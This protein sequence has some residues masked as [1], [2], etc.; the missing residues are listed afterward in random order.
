M[1]SVA[2]GGTADRIAARILFKVLRA[3]SGTPARYSSTFLG[4]RLPLATELRLPDFTFFMWAVLQ[5]L[6][7]LSKQPDGLGL[8]DRR[9]FP[10]FRQHGSG[11]D[12][13]HVNHRDGL[14]RSSGFHIPHPAAQRKISNVDFVIAQNRTDFSDHAGDVAIAEVDEIALKRGFHFD[15]IHVQQAWGILVQHRAFHHV[16]F[17]LSLQRN[18]KHAPRSSRRTLGLAFFLNA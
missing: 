13:V 11:H 3:G 4:A 8:L 17:P 18:R 9:Y 6:L 5:R 15:S 12:T 2:S 10:K 14:A 16:F 7:L 1:V